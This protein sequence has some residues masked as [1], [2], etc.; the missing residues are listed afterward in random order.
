MC[1]RDRSTRTRR[2]T[3][4]SRDRSE[5]V[6]RCGFAS[7]SDPPARYDHPVRWGI[8]LVAGLALAGAARADDGWQLEDVELR[9][10]V[11]AQRGHGSQSQAAGG[12]EQLWLLEPWALLRVRQSERTTHELTL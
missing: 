11:L 4:S 10:S 9:T 7:R 3:S 2:R 6:S 5:S 8:A 12:S 1:I